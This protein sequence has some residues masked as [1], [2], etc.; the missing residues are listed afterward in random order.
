MLHHRKQ[1]R[2][3]GCAYHALY[4]VTGEEAWLEHVEDIS[5]QRWH[6]RLHAAGLRVSVWF[7]DLIGNTTTASS[8]WLGLQAMHHGNALGYTHVPLLVTIQGRSSGAARH[9][10]AV[11]MPVSDADPVFVSDSARPEQLG[12][13]FQKFLAS[14]YAQA[15]EVETLDTTDLDASPF[16]SGAVFV[17]TADPTPYAM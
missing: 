13:T 12:M 10:V 8:F 16:Q 14:E 17:S 2:L 1:A 6:A 7:A 4:A 5:P 11:G 9:L 15:F 3:Y